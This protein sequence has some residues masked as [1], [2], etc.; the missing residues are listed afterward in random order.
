MKTYFA[1]NFSLFLFTARR[2]LTRV[3]ILLNREL[4][5]KRLG[6]QKTRN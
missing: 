1:I 4:I 6:G 3:K 5:L 2:Q